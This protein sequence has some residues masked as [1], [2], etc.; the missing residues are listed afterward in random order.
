DVG[1]G[2]TARGTGQGVEDGGAAEVGGTDRAGPP[3][4][5]GVVGGA[6]T[7]TSPVRRP[8]DHDVGRA[9]ERTQRAPEELQRG[10]P[11]RLEVGGGSTHER[12]HEG[13]GPGHHHDGTDHPAP[14]ARGQPARRR[15]TH[16]GGAG[17]PTSRSWS[18]IHGLNAHG[19]AVTAARRSSKATQ[20]CS[21]TSSGLGSVVPTT[22]AVNTGQISFSTTPE[23]STAR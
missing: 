17:R 19:A 7:D 21:A 13:R 16:E 4:A 10:G 23:A 3:A 14:S 12:W 18:T 22:R 8:G 6:G 5:P 20:R 11:H 9:G 15:A 1:V 2:R